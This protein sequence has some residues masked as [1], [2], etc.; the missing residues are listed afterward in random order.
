MAEV[1][2]EVKQTIEGVS[3]IEALLQIKKKKDLSLRIIEVAHHVSFE[4]MP[5]SETITKFLTRTL[6]SEKID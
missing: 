6:K 1:Y 4:E 5:L 3:V 2:A